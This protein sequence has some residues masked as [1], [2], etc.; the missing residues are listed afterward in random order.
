[1]QRRRP[2]G[3]SRLAVIDILKNSGFDC[4]EN[5]VTIGLDNTKINGR[6]QL[7]WDQPRILVDGAHNPEALGALMKCVGAHVPYDSM[8]CVFGC[9]QDKDIDGLLDKVALGGDK[10]IFTKAANQPRAVEPDELV[11]RFAER[12][13]RVCQAEEKLADA[14]EIAAQ[15]ASRDDLICITGSFYLVGEAKRYLGDLRARRKAEMATA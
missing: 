3:A 4:A 13:N 12:H 6:M 9:C 7:V 14:L 15:A 11:R 5:Q 10:V 1:M 8:V 2:C